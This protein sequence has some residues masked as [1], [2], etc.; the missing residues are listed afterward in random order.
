MEN[1]LGSAETEIENLLS[2]NF[3]L[4]KIIAEQKKI[5]EELFRICKSPTNRIRKNTNNKTLNMTNLSPM[6]AETDS[7]DLYLKFFTPQ[8][9]TVT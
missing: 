6:P 5:I 4:Q 1:K 7:S 2:E 8:S 3:P 9:N